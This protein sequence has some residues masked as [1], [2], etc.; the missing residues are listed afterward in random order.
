MAIFQFGGAIMD[1]KMGFSFSQVLDPASGVNLTVVA[2]M[3]NVLFILI[4]FMSGAY[5][6]LVRL[7]VLSFEVLRPDSFSIN[8]NVG[9]TVARMYS[10]VL[11]YALQLAMPA[12]AVL[13]TAE[14]GVGVMMKAVPQINV[15]IVNIQLKMILGFITLIMIVPILGGFVTRM[16]D[17][18]FDNIQL[19]IFS[20]QHI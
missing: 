8:S 19:V 14:I 15:F 6:T 11:T 9:F 3:L 20:L 1:Y 2:N 16:I 17:L 10:V 13:M 5:L 18:A 7:A 12:L 4:F